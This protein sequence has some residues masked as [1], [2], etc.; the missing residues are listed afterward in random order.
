MSERLETRVTIVARWLAVIG[1]LGLLGITVLTVAD[2]LMRWLLNHSIDGVT[3]INKLLITVVVATFFPLSLLNHSHV[4]IRFVG[5]VLGQYG[6]ATLEVL[7]A[8]TTLT[9]FSVLEWQLVLYTRDLASSG[10][11]TWVLGWPVAPW[12]M[13]AT[14]ILLFCVPVQALLLLHILRT[15][16]PRCPDI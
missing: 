9:F 10:E 5:S 11:T 3:E 12:W 1:V 2:V 7:A 6:R 16:K 13:T 14:T 8:I 15:G 4:A